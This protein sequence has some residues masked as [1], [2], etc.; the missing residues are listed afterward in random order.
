M[1]LK[2]CNVCGKLPTYEK[3]DPDASMHSGWVNITCCN[4]IHVE[5]SDISLYYNT[6]GMTA[7][8]IIYQELIECERVAIEKWNT[9]N[10]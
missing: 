4:K 7:W 3:V 8:D 1:E 10:S 2:V 5:P 6:S 9:I